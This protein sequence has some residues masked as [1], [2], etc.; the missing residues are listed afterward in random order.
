MNNNSKTSGNIVFLKFAQKEGKIER[1]FLGVKYA[2]GRDESPTYLP[3]FSSYSLNNVYFGTSLD[4]RL[5]LRLSHNDRIY[6]PFGKD[7]FY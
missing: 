7:W 6:S 5:S 2:S 3:R 1:K 4:N